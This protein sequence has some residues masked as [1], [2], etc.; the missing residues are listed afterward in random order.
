MRIAY[1]YS[2]LAK[3]GGTERMITEKANYFSDRFGYDVTIISCFQM[4]D[5]TNFFPLS[6]NVKQL[7]LGIPYFLQ[8]KYKYPK[9]L[10]IK[11]QTNR[12]LKDHIKEAIKQVDPDILI[13]VSRFHANFISNIKCRAKKI[14][15]CHEAR[16]NTLYDTEVSRSI[17]NRFF[18]Y[19]YSLTYFRSIERHA[20]AVVTLTEGDRKLWKRAKRTEV[21]PNFTT[22]KI[23]Q[24]SNCT[25]KRVIAAGRLAWEKGFGRLI[26]VWAI[27]A[28]RHPDWHLDIFGQGM[29]YD[30]LI[31]LIKIY[32]VKNVV[33]H[34]FTPDISLE[35][36][37]SSICAVPS[38][39]EGFSLV[40]L[41][42]MKHGVPCVAYDCP[43]GPRSIISD[44]YSGFLVEDGDI[45]IFAER[46]CRLIE[47]EDLRK[48]F[49][50]AAIEKADTYD[51]DVIMNKWKEFYEQLFNE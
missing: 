50:K 25:S 28:S 10:W 12:L 46:L 34:D 5:E 47:D 26:Q 38:Y 33:I 51:V 8:Y 37:T 35:Y 42:A 13:G 22:I 2:T 41:E 3:T 40:I 36:T 31:A 20:D 19:L 15:E 11:W 9:R 16:Y 6:N 1:I 24:H 14:I 39:F 49:S 30:T 44:C 29:M 45:R 43:F 32:K 48:H 7:N 17:L 27:V 4:T 23:R 21:I 18:I